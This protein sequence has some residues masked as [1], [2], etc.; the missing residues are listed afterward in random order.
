LLLS[1]LGSHPGETSHLAAVLAIGAI[2]A[3]AGQQGVQP[4]Y[5][6]NRHEQPALDGR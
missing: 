2:A 4:S 1:E 6:S 3:Q 5:W